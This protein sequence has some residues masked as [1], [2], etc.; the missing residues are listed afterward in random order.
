MENRL[1]KQDEKRYDE[2]SEKAKKN[3]ESLTV[4]ELDEWKNLMAKEHG[5]I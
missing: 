5:D 2:L 4:D 1:T 3:F